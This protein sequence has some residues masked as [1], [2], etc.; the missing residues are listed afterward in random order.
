MVSSS[1]VAINVPNW[2]MFFAWVTLDATF[3]I[4]NQQELLAI[5]HSTMRYLLFGKAEQEVLFDTME[6]AEDIM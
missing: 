5:P 3:F 4:G 2:C 6:E 1:P